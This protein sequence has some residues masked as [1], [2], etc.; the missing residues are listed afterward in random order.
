MF[1]PRLTPNSSHP[2]SS[3]Q[4]YAYATS[5]RPSFPVTASSDLR[6]GS[7]QPSRTSRPST[8]DPP[9]SSAS[10]LRDSTIYP[11]S[12]AT[13]P[14]VVANPEPGRPSHPSQLYSEQVS[15]FAKATYTGPS[16]APDVTTSLPPTVPGSNELT[17]EQVVFVNNLRGLNV[18]AAE[19]A[20]LMEVMRRERQGDPS[21]RISPS[22]TTFDGDAPPRYDY[23]NS[24]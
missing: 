18:P 20:R 22:N 7:Y 5:S 19:I 16:P 17:E 10:V 21:A 24:T 15:K 2:P 8:S 3:P 12:T 6:T 9:S 14:F 13:R 4:P 23:N 1:D 11:S